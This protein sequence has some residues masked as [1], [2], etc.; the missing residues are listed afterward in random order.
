MHT[1]RNSYR[2]TSMNR[3]SQFVQVLKL[4]VVVVESHRCMTTTDALILVPVRVYYQVQAPG[5]TM[6]GTTSTTA[7]FEYYSDRVIRTIT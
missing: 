2:T 5:G 6:G 1:I 7:V 3:N 4:L